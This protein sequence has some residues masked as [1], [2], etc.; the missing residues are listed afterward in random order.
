M[1]IQE[2]HAD[3]EI[4]RFRSWLRDVLGNDGT[5]AWIYSCQ[6]CGGVVVK[7]NYGSSQSGR[8][9]DFVLHLGLEDEYQDKAISELL[10]AGYTI[11]S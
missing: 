1:D 7:E 2:H 6:E 10:T 3:Q 9:E 4:G 5:F 8:S 11:W